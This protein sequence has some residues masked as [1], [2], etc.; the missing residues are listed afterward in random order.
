MP[1]LTSRLLCLAA[2]IPLPLLAQ[3][4]A[5]PAAGWAKVGEKKD[6][7]FSWTQPMFDGF[8]MAWTPVTMAFF[9]V[10]FSL[11]ALMGFLEYRHPGGAERDGVFGLTTTR[12]DRL[13]ISILGSAYILLIVLFFFGQAAV[14]VAAASAALWFAFVFWKV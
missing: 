4:A 13:F 11:I 6:V 8:W 1:K 10:V 14:L 7:A 9:V 5:K 2:L 3:D 12:G